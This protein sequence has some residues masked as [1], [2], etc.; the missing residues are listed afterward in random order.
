MKLHELL[1]RIRPNPK[2]LE[3]EGERPIDNIAGWGRG[4]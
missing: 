2:P 4:R 3:G 1:K